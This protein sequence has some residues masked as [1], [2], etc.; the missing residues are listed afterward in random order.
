MKTIKLFLNIKQASRVC[1][2]KE[3]TSIT[4]Y[5]DIKYIPFFSP[6]SV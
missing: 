2:W 4:T 6:V 1:R 5:Y 3:L